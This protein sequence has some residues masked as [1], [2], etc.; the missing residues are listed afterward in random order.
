ME[1]Q[2]RHLQNKWILKCPSLL[3]FNSEGNNRPQWVLATI[4]SNGTGLDSESIILAVHDYMS[5]GT[6]F[7]YVRESENRD[8]WRRIED[9]IATREGDCEDLAHVEASLLRLALLE[10]GHSALAAGVSVKAGAIRVLEQ[11]FG[12]AIV[13]IAQED[14]TTL[15]LD[16]TD[17]Q[18]ISHLNIADN[19]QLSYDYFR[20][21]FHFEEYLTYNSQ[22]T[23]VHV[24]LGLLERFRTGGLD[25]F[26]I[27]QALT[28]RLARHSR[29]AGYRN[30]PRYLFPSLPGL[31]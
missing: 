12:H 10:G 22:G 14:G 26:P 6:E 28:T 24:E 3:R 20:E 5:S 31:D 8:H 27:F 17:T 15:M 23:I 30:C 29:S 18:L 1:T 11:D 4:F 7:T 16:P 21:I 19:N 25:L 2:Y 13:T 9:V